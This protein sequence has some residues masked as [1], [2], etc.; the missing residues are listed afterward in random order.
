MIKLFSHLLAFLTLFMPIGAMTQVVFDQT[1]GMINL[2]IASQDFE[3]ANNG[4]DCEAADDFTIPSGMNWTIDSVEIFGQYSNLSD[5]TGLRLRFYEDDNSSPGDLVYEKEWSSNVDPDGDGNVMITF[6][7]PFQLAGGTYWM[8]AQAIK[9]LVGG[10][11]WYWLRDSIGN[12]DVFQWKN[13]PGGFG[14]SC[15]SFTPINVCATSIIEPGTAFKLYGCDGG[16]DID[17]LP[18]D[19]VICANDD[20][21]LSVDTSASAGHTFLWSTGDTLQSIVADSSRSYRVS[22]TDTSSGCYTVRCAQIDVV[23]IPDPAI[24]DDTICEFGGPASVTFFSTICPN[25]VNIWNELDTNNIL[26]SHTE[27]GLVTKRVLDTIVGC[28]EVDTAFIELEDVPLEFFPGA[29]NQICLGDSL[30]LSATAG[31]ESYLWFEFIN[32][33]WTPYS[34]SISI[35]LQ[36]TGQFRLLVTSAFGCQASDTASLTVNSN[37]FPVL[38]SSWL[39][40]SLFLFTSEDYDYYLWSDGSVDSVFSP[41]SNGIYSVLVTDS[42]GCMSTDEIAVLNVSITGPA[43]NRLMFFPNPADNRVFIHAETTKGFGTLRLIDIQGNVHLE[44]VMSHRAIELQLQNIPAGLY[45]IQLNSTEGQVVKPLM[46]N[47]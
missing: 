29:E 16:P 47:H 30:A 46:V 38:Q 25:C 19:T 34:D 44:R 8:S 10:G 11:Q 18:P 17:L 3:V 20:Y 1:N 22:V 40:D 5:S 23:H 36:S 15:F 35:E 24:V 2:G 43:V 9:P 7:C 12:G 42:N 13:P 21:E 39:G 41:D 26:Y 33:G 6:D 14:T 32:P 45:V 28:F 31:Y 4:Y 37:P 27:E